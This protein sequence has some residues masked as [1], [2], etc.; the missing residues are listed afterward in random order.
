MNL[1]RRDFVKSSIAA[2]TFL[3]AGRSA[4]GQMM[5]GGGMMG[6]GMGTTI[7]PPPGA[8]FKDPVVMPNLSTIPG[9]VEVNVEAKVSPVNVNGTIANLLTYN[10][11]YPAP[12]IRANKG[13]ILKIHFKNSLPGMGT[14]ILGQQRE[15]T[16]LHT[17][18][19][20]V[21]PSGNSDNSML[22]FMS[23]DTFDYE[24]D[25]SNQYPSTLNIYH[26][27]VHETVAEQDWGGFERHSPERNRA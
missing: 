24:Y 6:G 8:A 26:P 7:D 25:L 22:M 5:G 18:G 15:M 9:L 1:T 16:N 10:D 19:L 12:T 4:L 13:D 17:H 11:N 27:H 14:N 21:S 20:H 23:G 2:A 3:T